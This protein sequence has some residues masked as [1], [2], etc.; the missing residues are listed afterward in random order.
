MHFQTNE[1]MKEIQ[2]KLRFNQFL[3]FICLL[4]TLG[5]IILLSDKLYFAVTFVLLASFSLPNINKCKMDI[6]KLMKNE[7]ETIE[8]KVVDYF[9]ES[10]SNKSKRWILFLLDNDE[11]VTEI[12]FKTDVNL[13][14][15]THVTVKITP[16]MKIPVELLEK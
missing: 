16:N 5:S 6:D 7:L 3:L 13:K 10:E 11:Q 1:I 14:E 8:G 4:S 2:K 12:F 9:P 15:K